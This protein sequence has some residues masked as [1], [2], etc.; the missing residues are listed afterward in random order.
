MTNKV[1][2]Q[3]K[4]PSTKCG[5]VAIVGRPNVGKSTLLNHLIGQKISITSRK[6][7][8]TRHRMLGIH[9]E[10]NTQA[11][12]VDTP[13]IHGEE[14]RAINRFMNRA[15]T[16]SLVDVDLII[17][18]VDGTTWN[19]DDQLVL[20][21]LQGTK[22]PVILLINKVDKVQD[23]ASL[24]P[25][26]AW[27]GEQFNFAEIVPGSALKG[28]NLEP[29][30]KAIEQYLPLSEFIFPEDAITDRSMRFLAAETIRE[31]LIRQLG[32]ELPYAMVV[33]VESYKTDDKGVVHIA[34]VVLVERDG[35]K[36]IVIGKQGQRLKQV[37]TDAR[38][39]LEQLLDA[40][41]FM[42]LWVKVKDGWADDEK[43]LRSL[44]FDHQ[45]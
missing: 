20:D 24:L 34:A 26:L 6:P 45:Q 22:I 28:T 35:Q 11:I 4:E 32:D 7:Q 10:K 40:K 23:K 38:K 2:E 19:T 1:T 8:T 37:G 41:V 31:K 25:H 17:F 9:T 13:G 33:E 27:L 29:I 18:I 5:Y 42:Q 3:P 12:F 39:D 43:A 15:A 30:K 16:S 36:S 21:K 44:G 14:K